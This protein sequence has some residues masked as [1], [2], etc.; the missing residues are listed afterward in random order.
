MGCKS[1]MGER[2]LWYI[3]NDKREPVA[4][5]TLV[6]GRWMQENFEKRVVKQENIG[7]YCRVST[8]FLCIDH[9][10][11]G[12]GPP[13]L[14]ETMVFPMDDL[15]DLD[16]ERYFTWDEAAEGHEDMVEKWKEKYEILFRKFD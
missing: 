9:N 5:E 15:G 7:D 3:L 13:I 2:D 11:C 1:W 4:V 6:A 8:V 12:S 14:F 16:C 10:F